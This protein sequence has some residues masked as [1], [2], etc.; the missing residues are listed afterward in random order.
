MPKVSIIGSG[1]WGTALG[2]ALARK[3]NSV[4]LWTRTEEEAQKLNEEREN[5]VFLPGFRFPTRFTPTSSIEEALSDTDLVLLVVPSQM[6]RQN[7]QYLK[8]HL[9]HSVPIV[10]AAK[11]LEVSSGKRMTEVISEVMGRKY[12]HNICA[13]SGPNIAQEVAEGL[14]SVTVVASKDEAAADRVKQI[15][16]TRCFC[17]FTSKDIVGVELGGALK[18]IVGLAAGICDG[19]GSYGNNAKGALITRGVAEVTALGIALKAD[20]FTFVGL[21]CLGDILATSY[22]PYS[23]SRHVGEEL[24]KGYSLKE[25]LDSMPHKAEGIETTLVAQK[26]ARDLKINMPITE[27]LYRVFYENLAVKQA[28]LAL[29]TPPTE[30]ELAAVK[31]SQSRIAT[32]I[33]APQKVRLGRLSLNGMVGSPEAV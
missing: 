11:G 26:L 2:I 31:E 6:M 8:K 10:S 23:R 19:L 27:Q 20:P 18:N 28:A 12:R 21:A 33:K 14:H 25:I 13:L 7:V 15:V 9:K 29:L 32:E 16:S 22:S 4:K 1:A 24:A 30:Q 3:G 17:V 5:T